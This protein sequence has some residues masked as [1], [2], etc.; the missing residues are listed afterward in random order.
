[1]QEQQPNIIIV[2][3]GAG[4]LEL[5]TWPGRKLGNKQ[6]AS[7]TLVDAQNT[8]F[9]KPLLHEVAAGSLNAFEDEL[10]YL[11]QVKWNHFR[12]T[13]GRM[14]TLDRHNQQITLEAIID[15]NGKKSL[16]REP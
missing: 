14:S 16:R 5:A 2:G 1:M 7:I 3:G 11:A 10:S 8:H 4:G 12:F 15:D 9:W 13:P 6:L